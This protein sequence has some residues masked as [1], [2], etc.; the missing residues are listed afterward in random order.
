M[1]KLIA[2][3]VLGAALASSSPPTFA[4]TMQSGASATHHT[5]HAHR[6]T[7]SHKSEMRH[8]SNLS[9]ERARAGAEHMRTMHGQ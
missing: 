4:A 2:A 5:A 3:I 8:R 7:R 1:L 9:R 6:P